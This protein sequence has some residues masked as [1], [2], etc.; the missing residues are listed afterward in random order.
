MSTFEKMLKDYRIT[1]AEILYRFPDYPNLVQTYIWQEF[2][3][4]PEF[5]MLR[6]FLQF[7][8]DN[9]DGP[10]YEV[11]VAHV[12]IIQPISFCA[13]SCEWTLH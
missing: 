2:D 13:V 5:P 8:E 1:T 4:P 3:L 11:R 9:L 10:L 12:G 7:W 6:K